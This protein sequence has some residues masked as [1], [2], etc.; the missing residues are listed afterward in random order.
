MVVKELN[1]FMKVEAEERSKQ[2]TEL[3]AQIEREVLAALKGQVIPG[4]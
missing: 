1:D 4:E 2:Q 3:V